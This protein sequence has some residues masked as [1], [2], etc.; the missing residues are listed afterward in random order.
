MISDSTVK[1]CVRCGRDGHLSKDCPWPLACEKAEPLPQP[2]VSELNP[3]DPEDM[4]LIM[5][6]GFIDF[7]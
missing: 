2:E 7:L 1:V 3:D 5:D 6:S 4:K